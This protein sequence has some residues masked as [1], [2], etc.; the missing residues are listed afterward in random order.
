MQLIKNTSKTCVLDPLP[1]SVLSQ[2]I[3]ELSP[4]ITNI[5]NVSIT[6][7]DIPELLKEAVV[8]PLLNK[9]SLD[10]DILSNCSPVS[11]LPQLSKVLENVIAKQIQEH[12]FAMSELYQ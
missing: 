6:Q 1:S 11:Y 2:C 10:V 7:S 4:L 8:R 3:E 12:T 9:P 5:I